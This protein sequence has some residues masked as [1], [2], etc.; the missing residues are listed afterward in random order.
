[1]IRIV[2]IVARIETELDDEQ[3]IKDIRQC[4]LGPE[5]KVEIVDIKVAE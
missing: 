5:D 1:M 3:L 2:T 4:G